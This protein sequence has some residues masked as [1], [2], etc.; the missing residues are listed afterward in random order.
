MIQ[1]QMEELITTTVPVLMRDLRRLAFDIINTVI[2][3][4]SAVRID[5]MLKIFVSVILYV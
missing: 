4:R 5:T 2:D 1:C 3:M